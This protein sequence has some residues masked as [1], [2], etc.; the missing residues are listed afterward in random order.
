MMGWKVALL[1]GGDDRVEGC[2]ASGCDVGGRLH[3]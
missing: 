2:I 1:V 3:C